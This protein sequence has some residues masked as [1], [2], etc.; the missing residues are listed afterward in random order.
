MKSFFS[1]KRGKK[2]G[3]VLCTGAHYTWVNTVTELKLR[4]RK[5]KKT[6]NNCKNDFKTEVTCGLL[7][8]EVGYDEAYSICTSLHHGFVEKM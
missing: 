6:S 4:V 1:E 8:I 7:Y 5:L 3:C 2:L